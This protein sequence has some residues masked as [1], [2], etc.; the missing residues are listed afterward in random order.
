MPLNNRRCLGFL[1][2]VFSLALNA[3][4]DIKIGDAFPDLAT[5]KLE[6]KLPESLKD[7]VV[8]VDFWA[9]WCGPCIR[10][11][12]VMEELRRAYGSKGFVIIAVN[13]DEKKRDMENF[14]KNHPVTFSVV[15][16][17]RQ[18][19]VEQAGVSAMPSSFLID[20]N[21]KVAFTHSGFHGS[22]TK[23]QYEQEIE[24]LLKQN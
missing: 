15:R 6:G 4:A 20:K 3:A 11:F 24:S 9:S 7:K 14:L 8:L 5:C 22:D 18:K 2:L 10:S 23:K 16:D 21:G 12:P 17:A 13:V 1:F 19:L